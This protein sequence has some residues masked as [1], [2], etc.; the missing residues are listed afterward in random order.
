LDVNQQSTRRVP[1]CSASALI[2]FGCR[3]YPEA[4]PDAPPA[5]LPRG[6]S[7]IRRQGWHDVS[8]ELTGGREFCNI[9]E[10]GR[11]PYDKRRGRVA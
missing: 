1:A 6:V 8:D 7:E 10:A 2:T 5:G 9:R 4:S 3:S 11:L